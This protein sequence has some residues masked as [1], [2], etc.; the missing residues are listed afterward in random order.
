MTRPGSSAA[1]ASAPRE[2]ERRSATPRLDGKRI[3]IGGPR[4]MKELSELVRNL[5][6]EPLARPLMNT[7]PLEDPT[8][9]DPL[10]RLAEGGADWVVLTTGV[11]TR[12]LVAAAERAGIRDAVLASIANA[13]IA[14]RGYKT[15][16]A[17]REL[18]LAPTV[19]DT[20]GSIEGLL[21]ALRPH[22]IAGARTTVQ[23]YGTNDSQ[24]IDALRARGALVDELVLYRYTP[25]AGDVVA[26]LLDEIAA[27]QRRCRR[28]HVG[29]TG[30]LSVRSG[31]RARRSRSRPRRVQRRGAGRALAGSG[32]IGRASRA[33]RHGH[34]RAGERAHGGDDH[35]ARPALRERRRPLIGAVLSAGRC[36]CTCPGS[37]PRDRAPSRAPRRSPS[38]PRSGAR[39]SA[40]SPDPC[41]CCD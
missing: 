27:A 1:N 38:S 18:G 12:S 32:D 25:P 37:R 9:L 33:R 11:G 15:V 7:V 14:A 8:V 34:R 30:N 2:G 21:T 4:R 17:L 29:A 6:G 35:G 19:T 39:A 20:D 24:L 40:P 23:L 5:G 22:D 36:A 16:N 41:P 10:R 26:A 31:K 3:A 13:K 28:L